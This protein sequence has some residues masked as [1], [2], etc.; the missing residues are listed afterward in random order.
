[1]YHENINYCMREIILYYA[2]FL[3]LCIVIM[4][5]ES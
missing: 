5:S 1:M 3:L 4:N 2:N